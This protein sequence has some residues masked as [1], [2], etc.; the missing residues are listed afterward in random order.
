MKVLLFLIF[1]IFLN[2]QNLSAQDKLPNYD[3]IK[4]LALQVDFI[5]ILFGEALSISVEPKLSKKFSLNFKGGITTSDVMYN[6]FFEQGLKVWQREKE[7]K[8]GYHAGLSLRKYFGGTEVFD[9]VFFG[10]SLHYKEFNSVSTNNC[11]NTIEKPLLYEK[12]RVFDAGL[13]LG[14]AFLLKNVFLTEFVIDAGVR[15]HFINGEACM[16][17]PP[18]RI[19]L[20]EAPS[21]RILPYFKMGFKMGFVLSRKQN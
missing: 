14:I 1:S 17:S 13:E 10:P 4:V 3:P 12:R 2:L 7:S 19:H 21:R 9:G 8:I 18:F 11:Y 16:S 5:S 6:N 15:N 20:E